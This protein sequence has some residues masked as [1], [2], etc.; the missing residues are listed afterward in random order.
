MQPVIEKK[1]IEYIDLA[2]GLCILLV[3]SWHIDGGRLLYSNDNILNFFS[4]FR[5][6]LY[7]TLSGIFISIRG[8]YFHFFQKKINKLIIPL[9]FFITI[10]NLVFWIGKDLLGGTEKDW[11]RGDFEW[12]SPL[13]FFT[14]IPFFPDGS[15]SESGFNNYA[16]WFLPS[17]FNAY[18]IY[19]LID[20]V[21]SNHFYKKV[22]SII[23]IAI[24]GCIL[25]RKGIYLPFFL[26]SSMRALPFLLIG[27]LL[28]KKTSLLVANKFDKY[29]ILFSIGCFL[30]LLISILLISVNDDYL[31]Q[32][33]F[34]GVIGTV[35]IL[36]FAKVFVYIPI[37]SYIGR[38]SIIML[39]VHA[40]MIGFCKTIFFKVVSN[41][42]L[43]DCLVFIVIVAF[44]MIAIKLLTTYLPWF[45][46]QK[47]M[48][49]FE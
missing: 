3:V 13:I 34:N 31:I 46:A 41:L 17:L 18:M 38:Y 30:S 16:L 40:P 39:G 9:I 20:R 2:K 21:T 14:G 5:M 22:I 7:Y 45:V 33:Y 24:I 4:A 23:A 48:I 15:A 32:Y 6:P 47:D 35:G 19:M 49:K 1:R 12:M 29:N 25:D 28:R 11:F 8:E 36:L 10:T 37:V 27:E 43:V 42:F 44:G 26:I